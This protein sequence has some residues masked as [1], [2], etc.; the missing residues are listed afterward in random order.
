MK[1][2]KKTRFVD[3]THYISKREIQIAPQLAKFLGKFSVTKSNFVHLSISY[4]HL[5]METICPITAIRSPQKY[6]CSNHK[7]S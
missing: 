5:I 1:C 6:C 3:L 2:S 4:I 7:V